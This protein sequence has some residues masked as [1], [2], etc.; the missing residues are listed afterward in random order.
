MASGMKQFY[1]GYPKMNGI[2]PRIGE[3]FE[4][5]TIT[6]ARAKGCEILAGSDYRHGYL[7]HITKDGNITMHGSIREDGCWSPYLMVNRCLPLDWPEWKWKP[8]KKL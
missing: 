3:G 6:E 1:V 8:V 7:C 4:A 5:R 2:P